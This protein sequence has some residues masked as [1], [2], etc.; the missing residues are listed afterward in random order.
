MDV[1]PELT[2]KPN[3]PGLLTTAL[4]MGSAVYLCFRLI[5]FFGAGTPYQSL[6]ETVRLAQFIVI[7]LLLVVMVVCIGSLLDILRTAMT[8]MRQ[9]WRVRITPEG[10]HHPLLSAQPIRWHVVE[11]ISVANGYN[12]KDIWF[13]LDPSVRVAPMFSGFVSLLARKRVSYLR[14]LSHR[15]EIEPVAFLQALQEIV[16]E[17]LGIAYRI[18]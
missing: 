14:L 1:M 2:L 8:G 3:Y 17:R 6:E 13:T 18:N 5:L 7:P 15:F 4:L 12:G 9:N 10:I 16:P 11:E